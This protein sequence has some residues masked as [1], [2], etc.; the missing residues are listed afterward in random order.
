MITVPITD[1]N[2]KGRGRKE[3]KDISKLAASIKK[4][5]VM[6]PIVVDKTEDGRYTLI[7]G[8]RRLRACMMADIADVPVTIREETDPLVMKEMELE[9]NVQRMDLKWPEECEIL[10]QLDELKRVQTL[11]TDENIYDQRAGWVDGEKKTW[12]YKQTADLVGRSEGT[13]AQDIKLAR[14]VRENP[15][16]KKAVSHLPKSMA[17]KKAMVLLEAKALEKALKDR[18]IDI[19]QELK[20][21]PCEKLIKA[22]GDNSIDM[23]LTD[24]P[25][26]CETMNQVGSGLHTN[27]AYEA[28]NMGESISMLSVYKELIPELR[29]VLKP[30]AH[31]YIFHAMESYCVI[32]EMLK[33]NGFSVDDMPII[34][35]KGLTTSKPKDWHYQPSYEAITFAIK[36]PRGRPLLKPCANVISITPL[37]SSKKAHPLQKPEDLLKIFIENSSSIGETILDPFA[38]SAST[39][40]TA[41]ALHRKAIGFELN[42]VNY[43]RALKF[44]KEG[45]EA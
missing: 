28:S 38:G 14:V 24:P 36:E 8:E 31:C 19:N 11:G 34:W 5:G 2:A 29:R 43:E 35:A 23:L 41:R 33:E 37:H 6:H 25:F 15:D 13:V 40:K 3:F 10:R 12:T 42:E 21:G 20:L 44:L 30:G 22:L 4:F 7:A 1:I 18:K 17:R 32:H 39:L 16:I 9:E 27:Y 26:A 45:E